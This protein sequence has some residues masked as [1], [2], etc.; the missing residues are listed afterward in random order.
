MSAFLMVIGLGLG[1]PFI[2]QAVGGVDWVIANADPEKLTFLGKQNFP[3]WLSGWLPLFFLTVGDQNFYQRIKA[4]KDLKTARFGLLGCMVACIIIMPVVSAISFSSSIWFGS[5]IQPGQSLIAG[6]T[7]MPLVI[8][9][10]VLAAASAFTITTG[11]SFLLSAS[12]NASVD[13][14]KEHINPAA[15]DAQQVKFSRWFILVAGVLAFVILQFFPSV[16]A[17]QYWS[18]TI[19]GAGITPALIAALVWKRTSKV[20]GIASMLIGTGMVIV[21][22]AGSLATKL[23]IQTVLVAIP[24]SII[25]LV[26]GSLVFPNKPVSAKSVKG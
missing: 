17:I 18:Y 3:S 10:F 14:Y 7:L 4:G 26:L 25:V 12:T 8:G 23:G 6:A 2:L 19:Y 24:V 11:D 16:L 22:E 13:V 21:W 5:N 20:G 15:T 1:V 9:G